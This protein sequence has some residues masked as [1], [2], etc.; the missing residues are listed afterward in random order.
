M[1]S[2]NMKA[3]GIKNSKDG[4][5]EL[6]IP[7]EDPAPDEVR[8]RHTAVGINFFDYAYASG[9][10]PMEDGAKYMVLGCEG[11]GII[12]DVGSDVTDFQVGEKVA[13]AISDYG[14][15]CEYRNITTEWLLRVPELPNLSDETVAGILTK[16]LMARVLAYRVMN[17]MLLTDASALVYSAAGGVGHLL[18]QMLA[19]NPE[20]EVYG[21]VGNSEKLEF[22]KNLGCLEVVNYQRN[23]AWEFIRDQTGSSGVDLVYDGTGRENFET[24][25]NCLGYMG[26]LVSYGD[27]SGK[28][29]DFNP[30]LLNS[31]SLYFTRPYL[32]IYLGNRA[33]YILSAEE[34]FSEVSKQTL[35]P[36]I[37]TYKLNEL[38]KV[39]SSYQHRLNMG[40]M[41]ISFARD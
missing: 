24:S 19:Q 9:I 18:V 33:E 29:L 12:E 14:A 13:Y 5:V 16:G 4:L 40:S 23:N 21:A 30:N 36:Y 27:A 7:E 38:P 22:A 1:A 8:I 2:G 17:T 10:Y 41:V 25:L 20:L 35:R 11:C 31:R 6:N 37:N 34:L 32:Q 26:L 3:Y 15:F 28:L 39:M